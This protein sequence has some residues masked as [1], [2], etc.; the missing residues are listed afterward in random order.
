MTRVQVEC[1]ACGLK[2]EISAVRDGRSAVRI[3]LT[4]GCEAVVAWGATIERIE[5]REPLGKMPAAGAFWQSA[6]EHLK[7][8]TCPVPV[9]VLKAIEVEIGAALPVDVHIQFLPPESQTKPLRKTG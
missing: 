2:A 1:G 3:Q 5:W 4:S 7:H 6:F 8:R 9:A